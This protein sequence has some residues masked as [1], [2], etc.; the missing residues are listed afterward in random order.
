[1]ASFFYLETCS[2]CKRIRQELAFGPEV[3]LVEIK[4]Q[5]ISEEQIDLMKTL[6]GSYEALFSRRAMKYRAMGLHEQE[7]READYR[8]L[9]LEEY[10]FLK[11]PVLILDD[12][13]FVGNT[14]KVVAAAK[15]ALG[16][17]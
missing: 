6:A 4:S 10:T 15:E 2:T 9:I 7:L 12:Q 17:R 11:R 5:S 8:R 3:E 13:I 14:K 1:M 16:G